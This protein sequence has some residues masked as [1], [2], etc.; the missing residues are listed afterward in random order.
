MEKYIYDKEGNFIAKSLNGTDEEI[1]QQFSNAEFI[2]EISLGGKAKVE[3]GS[4]RAYTRVDKIMEGT[5][6]LQDGEYIKDNEII[7]VQKPSKF[8]LWDS[9]KHKWNYDKQLEINSLNDELANLESTLL[10]KYD[11]LD[12]AIARKL[13]TLEKRLN[14][15][16]EELTVLIDEKYKKL[17][18]LEG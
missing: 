5:E 4:I 7:Y 2:L 11:E 18:E 16:I 10:S 8:H 15:E 6:Q 14:T 12:K 3:N 1:K 17:E 9:K 13:K